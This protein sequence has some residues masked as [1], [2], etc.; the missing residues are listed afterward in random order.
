MLDKAIDAAAW[1]VVLFILGPLI[2]IIGGSF[3]ETPWVAFPPTG[4]TLRWYQQLMHRGDFLQLVR[5]QYRSR[6]AVQRCRHGARRTG[7]DGLA[8]A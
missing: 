7:R 6:A 1:I 2:I 3:T 8:P 4:F 5:Y